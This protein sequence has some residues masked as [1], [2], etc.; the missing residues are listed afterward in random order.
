MTEFGSIVANGQGDKEALVK[1]CEGTVAS[2]RL[3]FEPIVFPFLCSKL[4]SSYELSR[5]S[6]SEARFVA[7][8]FRFYPVTPI[9]L[10]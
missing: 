4:A 8:N 9:S 10:I 5:F 3:N 6:H 1:G 7:E 2:A